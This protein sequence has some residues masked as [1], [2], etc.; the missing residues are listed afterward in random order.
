MKYRETTARLN[1]QIKRKQG[2]MEQLRGKAQRSN[3]AAYCEREMK[4]LRVEIIMLENEINS[5]A[6]RLV[7]LKAELHI[8]SE[9]PADRK[10]LGDF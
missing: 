3:A 6:D 7:D 8:S 4:D 2:Q 9:C 5:D 1:R 10:D